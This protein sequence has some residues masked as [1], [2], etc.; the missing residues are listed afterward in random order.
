MAGRHTQA[1]SGSL[2]ILSALKLGDHVSMS[3]NRRG[4]SDPGRLL[5]IVGALAAAGPWVIAPN[6]VFGVTMREKSSALMILGAHT[7]VAVGL[8]AWASHRTRSRALDFWIATGMVVITLLSLV[9][10]AASRVDHFES[11]TLLD[12][13]TL[14]RLTLVHFAAVNIASLR[15]E[16]AWYVL[17]AST[18]VAC[19][20]SARRCMIMWLSASVPEHELRRDPARPFRF[21]GYSL[22]L[23]S[24]LF[25]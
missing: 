2:P 4:D 15:P 5:Q 24:P 1:T 21:A 12:A 20:E 19:S 18:G 25:W 14:G 16:K 13:R 11:M 9:A 23:Q 7:A 10:L 3:S 8:L 17:K 22:S 6:V